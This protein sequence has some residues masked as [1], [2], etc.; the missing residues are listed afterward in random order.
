[1]DPREI[2][3][4]S[5]EIIESELTVELPEDIKPIV[6]RVI[7]ATADFSFAEN[8]RSTPNAVGIMR[9]LLVP[10]RGDRGPLYYGR[11]RDARGRNG[12]H[13]VHVPS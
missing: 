4:R 1:M 10:G 6:K 3:K 5:M 2:E 13:D 12:R 9:E 11:A 8:I 7:H